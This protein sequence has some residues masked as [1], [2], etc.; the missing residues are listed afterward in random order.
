MRELKVGDVVISPVTR[1]SVTEG[2]LYTV[3]R[4]ISRYIDNEPVF[5][6]VGDHGRTLSCLLTGCAHLG[7]EDWIRIEDYTIEVSWYVDDVLEVDNTL[8]L[9]QA[10]MVLDYMK[11]KHDTTVGINWDVISSTIDYLKERNYE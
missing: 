10:K 8:T 1:Y 2:D 7:G 4:I 9:A 6:V 3:E 5:E 11:R